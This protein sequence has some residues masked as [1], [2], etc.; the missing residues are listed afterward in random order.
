[1]R[2][3]ALALVEELR[4]LPQGAPRQQRQIALENEEPPA[5][6]AALFAERDR[7]P[8]GPAGWI[9]RM[10]AAM[11]LPQRPVQPFRRRDLAAHALVYEGVGEGPRRLLVLF[12]GRAMRPMMPV[13]ALLQHLPAACCDV[14]LLRDPARRSFL[15]GVEG[16]AEGFAALAPRILA[17]LPRARLGGIRCLGMSMGGAAALYAGLLLEAEQAVAVGG[18]HPA[19]RLGRLPV[20]GLDGREMDRALDAAGRRGGPTRL[21]ALHGEG[22]AR[23]AEAAL[24]LRAALPALRIL[25]VPGTAEHNLAAEMLSAGRLEGF[26]HRVAFGDFADGGPW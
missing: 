23:D 18:V 2:A 9:G 6:L 17:D 14:L 12:G 25:A 13:A 4:A 15:S 8:P 5:L 3:E 22:N 24:A 11:G 26:L 7:L 20:P 19:P 21:A 10:A 16:Y 1:M